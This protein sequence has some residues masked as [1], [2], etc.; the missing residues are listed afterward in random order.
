MACKL[1]NFTPSHPRLVAT[2]PP[3]GASP[4][5]D[6]IAFYDVAL[7]M[8]ETKSLARIISALCLETEGEENGTMK[9]FMVTAAFLMTP[10][11]LWIK[12]NAKGSVLMNCARH[13]GERW[14]Q[15]LDPAKV[16][17]LLRLY[18]ITVHDALKGMH[19]KGLL[20]ALWCTTRGVPMHVVPLDPSPDAAD[21]EE[22][23]AN[24]W[25]LARCVADSEV[26]N[27][28]EVARRVLGKRHRP[29]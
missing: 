1:R 7:A 6:L 8:N 27:T 28:A 5:I 22:G 20:N 9:H 19:A 2:I 10:R 26:T 29:A 11:A 18:Y 17:Q 12:I 14:A 25:A 21:A 23:D 16:E 13:I 24:L 3:N 4:K 15:C